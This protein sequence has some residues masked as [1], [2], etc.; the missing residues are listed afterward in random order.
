MISRFTY[1]R[2]KLV[3]GCEVAS[4]VPPVEPVIDHHHAADGPEVLAPCRDAAAGAMEDE[5]PGKAFAEEGHQLLDR[6]AR[7]GEAKGV[8]HTILPTVSMPVASSFGTDGACAVTHFGRNPA[9][10]LSGG[11]SGFDCYGGVNVKEGTYPP[12]S[13]RGGTSGGSWVWSSVETQ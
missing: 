11:W 8:H 5:A 12:A 4:G 6:D 13:G 2:D 9:R 10:F 3:L 1:G 7:A